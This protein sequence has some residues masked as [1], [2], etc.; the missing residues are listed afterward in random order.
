MARDRDIISD[1]DMYRK[2]LDI[3][4]YVSDS[5][6]KLTLYDGDN[7]IQKKESYTNNYN[8]NLA[9]PTIKH[10]DKMTA[11]GHECGHI[12]GKS[13]I[14]STSNMIKMWLKN[15]P[16]SIHN[17]KYNMYWSVYNIIE[18]QRIEYYIIRNWRAYIKRF[19]ETKKGLGMDM[20][21][22]NNP[23]DELLA[24]RFFRD[25]LV[26]SK[27]KEIYADVMEKVQGTGMYG[28]VKS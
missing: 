11:L 8:L 18:D 16:P 26:L 27:N 1:K 10:I 15:E 24:T 4:E 6:I 20:T 28:A 13:P 22:A 14:Q 3:V 17:I 21:Y 25:D 12:L 19:Y 2:I 7:Y 23:A 5:E 9:T